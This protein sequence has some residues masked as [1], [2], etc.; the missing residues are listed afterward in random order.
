MKSAHFY[1]YENDYESFG[2]LPLGSAIGNL[3]ELLLY[4]F[5]FWGKWIYRFLDGSYQ[6]C[7]GNCM[8][9][10]KINDNKILITSPDLDYDPN[11]LIIFADELRYIIDQW[12]E[13]RK[14]KVD[15]IIITQDNDSIN[16]EGKFYQEIQQ[17]SVHFIKE[18][19]QYEIINDNNNALELL[20]YFLIEDLKKPNARKEIMKRLHGHKSFEKAY[21]RC[22]LE[23]ENNKV[24][25]SDLQFH[26]R[27]PKITVSCLSLLNLINEWQVIIKQQPE[28]I[29]IDRYKD[30]FHIKIG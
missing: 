13:L 21:Q 10:K 8:L 19:D 16:I 2:Q 23:I 4:D 3:C 7:E 26:E 25:I 22:Y 9:L 30:N 27:L 5:G 20:A 28:F 14:Q 18:N 15:E 12:I 11:S 29:S 1:K 6:E 17:S 24:A